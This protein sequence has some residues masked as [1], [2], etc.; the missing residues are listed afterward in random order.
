MTLAEAPLVLLL[1]G[2]AAYAVLGGADFGAGVWQLM[3]G[4]SQRQ[5][6][7]HAHHAMGP[8]WEVNHVW[9]IFVLVVC[10]TG[11]PKAFGSIASTLAVPLFIAAIGIVFRGTA[12]ALRSGAA[13]MREQRRLELA[14]S[15]SSILT[16]FALGA[17]I[18][19][20]ASRRVPVGN[21]KGDLVTSWLNPT[22]I[23]VGVLFV[24][25][26]A[27]LAAVY[28]AGDASRAGRADLAS[29]FRWRALIAGVVAGA[30]A[31]A[32]LPVV[33]SDSHPLW[34]G[35]AHGDGRIALA[36]SIAAGVATLLLVWRSRFEPARATAALAVAAIVA[37]WGLAQRPLLLEGL[38][39]NQAAAG[40][41]TLI[42]ILVGFAGGA[43]LLVPSLV[44]LF[45]LL[46][47]GR[48]DAGAAREI[49]P[50]P[51]GGAF[52]SALLAPLALACLLAGSG[53][54]V[55]ANPGW[56]KA[57]G[58]AALLVFALLAFLALTLPAEPERPGS[59]S[60]PGS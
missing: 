45:G 2:L 19:G 9:L 20:I 5:I 39:V 3:P 37:G 16:P 12:Y 48:F 21:A 29:A 60:R 28:L 41:A 18:G 52:H 23:A 57:L 55:L 38:T 26:A 43:V 13:D 56:A 10:W 25:T 30:A 11:Y 14:L 58:V 35:L 27:Y 17:L 51:P 32:A 24:F 49:G 59:S 4:E 33:R 6:R 7:E 8:V 1:I 50:T 46:L 47:R 36:V 53:L 40:R 31:L 34:H 22:S 42:A 54:L 15:L 44:L